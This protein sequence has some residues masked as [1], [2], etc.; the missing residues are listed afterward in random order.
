MAAV[1]GRTRP[2]LLRRGPARRSH[3]PFFRRLPGDG[4]IIAFVRR[5][6]KARRPWL[7]VERGSRA[8]RAVVRWWPEPP[9]I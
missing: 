4:R 5:S 8:P 9:L 7:R 6:A 1:T 3:R 2:V